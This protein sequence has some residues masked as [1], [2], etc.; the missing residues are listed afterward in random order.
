MKCANNNSM[1]RFCSRFLAYTAV[2]P[3]SHKLYL[4]NTLLSLASLY[5]VVATP[6]LIVFPSARYAG[7]AT[8]EALLDIA[9]LFG[10][11]IKLRTTHIS[12]DGDAHSAFYSA[13]VYMRSSD[14]TVD[15]IAALPLEQLASAIGRAAN[16]DAP[17]LDALR[18]LQLLRALRGLYVIRRMRELRGANV[19]R[20]VQMLAGFLVFAHYLGLFWY[21]LAVWPLQASPAAQ[22]LH[23]WLWQNETLYDSATLYVCSLYWALAVMTNLKGNSAHES[24]QCLYESDVVVAPLRERIFTI[25]VFVIGAT[26]YSVIYG[27]IGQF[28]SNL[29]QAGQRYK[30]RVAEI[31]EFIRFHGLSSELGSK[32]H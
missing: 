22:P 14:F 13:R 19:V 23:P 9:F 31:E 24:R 3:H 21:A 12:R 29:Y 5:S 27:N 18:W 32:I 20:V 4:W 28:V 26:F 16:A 2:R 17:T 8:V 30:R 15:L 6:L 1:Q 11:F 25:F 10:V 7:H